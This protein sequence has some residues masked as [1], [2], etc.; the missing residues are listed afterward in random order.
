MIV[1]AKVTITIAIIVMSKKKWLVKPS[2]HI[3]KGVTKRTVIL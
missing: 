2:Y 3:N 1:R